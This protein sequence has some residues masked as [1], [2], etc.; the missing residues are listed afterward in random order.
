M[1]TCATCQTSYPATK[2]YFQPSKRNK[3]G[4]AYVCKS[5]VKIYM[6]QYYHDNKERMKAYARQYDL[7]NQGRRRQYY[8]NCKNKK[9]SQLINR[10]LASS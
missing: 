9:F 7:D 8:Q 6:K 4:F 10:R 5:C 1:K 2:K 3:D